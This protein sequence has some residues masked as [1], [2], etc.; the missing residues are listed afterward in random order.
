MTRTISTEPV[1]EAVARG[2]A[3]L[4]FQQLSELMHMEGI[5]V[6]G[7]IPDQVQKMTMYSATITT[8]GVQQ[9]EAAALLKYL[10]SKVARTAIKLSGLT[11][12]Q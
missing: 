5:N 2:E 11:P 1:G 6:I 7:L 10:S 4:G 8:G 9:E 3:E 12:V